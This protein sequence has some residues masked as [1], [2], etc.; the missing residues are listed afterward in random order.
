MPT[1]MA[2]VA[3]VTGASKGISSGIAQALA[4]AGAS[5]SELRLRQ[6]RR[7]T[8]GSEYHQRRG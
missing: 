7:R 1:L 6:E 2:K 5:G 8:G 3:I 4:A